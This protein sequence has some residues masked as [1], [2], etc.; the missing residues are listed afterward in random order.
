VS[1]SLSSRKYDV[2]VVGMGPA[3]AS[4]AYELSKRGISVLAFDKQVH[5]RYKVCGG[6]LSARIAR[7]LPS[8]FPSVVE[9]AVHRVRFTYGEQKFFLI[10]SPEPI[11]YMVMRQHFDQWLVEKARE[12][13]TEI[14]EGETVV[15]IRD[16]KEGVDVFTKQGCYRSRVVIGADGVMSVVAQQCFPGR[17]LRTIP[18]LESEVQ[19]EPVH[20]FQ[21]IPTALIS[22]QAAKKGYGWIF[23][24]Q[25][26]I[27]VGVG[28]FVNGTKRPKQSFSHFIDHEPTL[29]GLK[30][31]APLGY[32]L[33]IAQ[34]QAYRNGQ[35]WAGRLVRGR[36]MLVGDAGHLVDPLLG[37]GIY[38]AIRSG[39][40]AGKT[41]IANLRNSAI[42][43]LSEYEALVAAEFG[44][45][46]RVA[47]RL[48]T[49]IYGMP[50]SIHH[51]AGQRFPDAY[52]RVLHRYCEL[53]QGKE[54][55]QSL[56]NRI[57][58]RLNWPF[59]QKSCG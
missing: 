1:I 38:Y 52:Q 9:E 5:P 21:K 2:I 27:S 39:Q 11:A 44:P 42:H 6:G 43:H 56:W 54:T 29:A 47:G 55:Y 15:D 41:V 36:A 18:A 23:P 30:I 53:L 28:E 40:I 45:E 7:I 4:A 31:P 3:G 10:E 24:K 22:L 50:L 33:P 14:R 58:Q 13:G 8:D 35:A 19:G 49:I 34:A 48:G 26:G 46:F 57:L 51:W 20:S 37:E 16:G 59:A 17:S 12:V 25:Q 32:P